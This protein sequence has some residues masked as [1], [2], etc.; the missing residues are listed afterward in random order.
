MKK[1]R[2]NFWYPLLVWLTTVGIFGPILISIKEILVEHHH[3]VPFSYI[4][5][6]LASLLF[7][8][9]L[10]C[11]FY[12]LFLLFTLKQLPSKTVVILIDSIC[13]I[14]VFIT[15]NYIRGNMNLMNNMIYSLSGLLSSVI[16]KIYKK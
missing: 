1:K 5:F 4:P 12:I 3:V 14:G 9:P 7:S 2:I 11:I 10:L 6:I 15:L 13:I 16:F 8:L